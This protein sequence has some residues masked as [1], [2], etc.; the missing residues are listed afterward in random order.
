MLQKLF[1]FVG[2]HQFHLS[3]ISSKKLL[4]TPTQFTNYLQF[5][6]RAPLLPADGKKRNT[7]TQSDVLITQNISSIFKTSLLHAQQSNKSRPQQSQDIFQFR[8]AVHI[9]QLQFDNA[10]FATGKIQE[11]IFCLTGSPECINKNNINY[12]LELQKIII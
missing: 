5:M 7:D 10:N 11:I 6:L 8:A 4:F 9:Q 2:E 3:K 12:F 1:F